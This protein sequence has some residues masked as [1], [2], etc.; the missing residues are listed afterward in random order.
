MR[1]TCCQLEKTGTTRKNGNWEVLKGHL[2]I[3]TQELCDAVGEVEKAT[4]SQAKKRGRKNR[5][6]N[7]YE[8]KNN[9]DTKE[10]VGD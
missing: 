4:K 7:V 2:H 6:I 8:T 5:E 1:T 3:S 10:E 9:K